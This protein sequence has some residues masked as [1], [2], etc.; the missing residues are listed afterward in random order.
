VMTWLCMMMYFPLLEVTFGVLTCRHIDDSDVAYIAA[1]PYI[2]CSSD[3]T[4]YTTLLAITL[5]FI[6]IYAFGIPALF[7]YQVTY[8]CVFA[9]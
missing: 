4:Q 3:D 2:S 1:A 9:C 8:C 7:T 6:L 5:P